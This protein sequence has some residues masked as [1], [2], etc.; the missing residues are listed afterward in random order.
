MTSG[1][2]PTSGEGGN[3]LC[4]IS[5]FDG[6]GNMKMEAFSTPAHLRNLRE[7][8]RQVRAHVQLCLHL[9]SLALLFLGRFHFEE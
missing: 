5:D 7:Q 2:L 9:S 6:T 3:L 4:L 8:D 1:T